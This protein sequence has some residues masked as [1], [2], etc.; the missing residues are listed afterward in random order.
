MSDEELRDQITK[1]AVEIDK[2]EKIAKQKEN[3][4]T[5]KC[6]EEFDPKIKEIG[7]QLLQQQ[8][9]LNEVLKKINEL[10]AKKK[11]LLARTKKLESEYNSLNKT[12][13][14]YLLNHLKAIEKEKKTKT[15]DID[16]QIKTLEKELKSLE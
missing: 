1:I 5:N 6:N 16:N 12:K 13:E 9:I 3:Y 11:D 7:E 10:A 14:K 4:I 15:K 2:I 8:N